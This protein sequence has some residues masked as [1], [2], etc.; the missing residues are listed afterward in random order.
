MMPIL[1]IFIISFTLS[2]VLGSNTVNILPPESKPYDLSYADHIKNFWKWVLKIPAEENP[3]NDPTG[4]KCAVDQ[5]N[6]NST[7][8]YL[9]FNNGGL[10]ERTCKI[11]AGKAL[12]IP[13]M[14]VESSDKEIPNA[15]VEELD[16]S[17]KKDQDSVNSLYLKI[18]DKEYNY[19]NLTKYR[20]RTDGFEVVFPNNGIFGV[21]EGGVSKAVADGFYIIT[22]P[23]TKGNHTIHFKSSLICPD[24]DCADPNF[25]QDIKYNIIAE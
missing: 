7:V 10:S 3:I 9:A 23:L 1:S 16:K 5:S 15:S 25:V 19:E 22:E 8:F 13:V 2:P 11:S 6:S 14:Q 17:S 18:D 20:T 24:P 12:F 21:I 4:E